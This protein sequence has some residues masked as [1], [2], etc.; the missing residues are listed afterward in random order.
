[1]HSDQLGSTGSPWSV[2][3]ILESFLCKQMSINSLY[4]TWKFGY[5]SIQVGLEIILQPL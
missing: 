4:Q 5:F 3:I 1:M 2:H